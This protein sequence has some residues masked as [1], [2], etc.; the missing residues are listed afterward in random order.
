MSKIARND[1]EDAVDRRSR[2]LDGARA[3]F[4]RYGFE[5]SSMAD[6]AAGAGVSR[7]ALYHYFPGKEDVLQAVVDEL[8]ARHLNAATEALERSETLASALAALIDAKFGRTL[9]LVTAS[10][11]GVELV[12]AGHR[13]T[14][15]TI[16]DADGS[17]HALMVK[18]LEHHGRTEDAN[19]VADTLIAAARGL[20]RSGDS[21]VSKEKFDDRVHRIIA[22]TCK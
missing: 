21:Y 18:A 6:I 10:P 20:M 11:H 16:R 7:T 9:D 22:W 15:P 8:H 1:N 12:D 2:I 4:M 19:A 14:G 3:A 5:R 17:F 13:L